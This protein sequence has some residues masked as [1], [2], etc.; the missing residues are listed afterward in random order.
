MTKRYMKKCCTTNHQGKCKST[1]MK[2]HLTSVYELK[3]QKTN[4]VEVM[5][6]LQ[7]CHTAVR[8]RRRQW[9]PT[10]V[11]LPGKS[12]GQRSLVG[13][14]PWGRKELDSTERLHFHLFT[15]MHWRRKWQP[16]PVFF[17]GKSQGQQ[18][19]VGCRLW[20]CTESDTTEAS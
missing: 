7:Y 8:E 18:S 16:T 2:Y 9:N 12:H 17:P 3:G 20:G 11:L 19:L 5:K 4:V 15:F 14:S 13:C 1:T 10:P 6:K